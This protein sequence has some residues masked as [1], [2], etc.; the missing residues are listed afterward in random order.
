MRFVVSAHRA[1][2]RP[3]E[4][5]KPVPRVSPRFTVAGIG[6]A[7]DKAQHVG[8]VGYVHYISNSSISRVL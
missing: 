7:N 6:Q 8:D 5:Y 1:C 3:A 4:R 2:I